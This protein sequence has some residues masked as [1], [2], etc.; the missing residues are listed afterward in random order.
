MMSRGD[1]VVRSSS[2]ELRTQ[3]ALLGEH[4]CVSSKKK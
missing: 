3:S 1:I 4:L 2:D